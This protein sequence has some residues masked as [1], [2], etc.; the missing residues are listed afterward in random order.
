M[1]ILPLSLSSSLLLSLF[2]SS[3]SPFPFFYFLQ[4]LAVLAQVTVK[5]TAL[6]H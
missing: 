4:N 1:K 2:M 5:F 3:L 6:L